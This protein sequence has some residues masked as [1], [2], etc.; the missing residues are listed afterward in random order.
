M[1]ALGLNRLAIA[2]K[3]GIAWT[4]VN[5]HLCPEFRKTTAQ[6]KQTRGKELVK[7]LKQERGG[8]CEN[9][10]YNKCMA[11]LHFHH[12]DATQKKFG[13]ANCYRRSIKAIKAEIDKCQLLC[14]N[15]H[16]ELTYGTDIHANE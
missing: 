16:I 12:K 2:K 15:C 8:K 13:I 4:S 14:A 7:K 1:S 5:A 9:C 11:A 3:L 10:N 6:R